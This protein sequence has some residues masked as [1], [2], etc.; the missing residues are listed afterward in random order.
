[1]LSRIKERII[2]KSLF[3]KAYLES[4][5]ID[6]L[7]DLRD[8]G[9]FDNEWIRVFEM[10]QEISI[11]E[12]YII[13][14]DEIREGVFKLIYEYADS[15]DLASYVSDDFELMC[16]AYVAEF[17]DSWLVKMVNAYVCRK[18]PAGKLSE[19]QGNFKEQFQKLF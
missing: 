2:D 12:N 19:C 11:S 1:M 13:Q 14:I 6:N 5:N 10:L 16:K 8:E 3:D 15:S 7:L 18:I 4:I 9:E 17:N